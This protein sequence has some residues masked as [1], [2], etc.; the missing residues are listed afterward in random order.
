MGLVKIKLD[1]K[2]KN[3]RGDIIKGGAKGI[4]ELDVRELLS[5]F[6]LGENGA[7]EPLK[8]W[9]LAREIYE[10]KNQIMQLSES[11]IEYIEV[12][13]K[14]GQDSVTIKGQLLQILAEAKLKAVA[15]HSI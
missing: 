8:N 6:L 12:I 2:I 11:D 1:Y 13:I 4:E 7:N 9:K 5:G 3:V 15:E 14:K 10:Y